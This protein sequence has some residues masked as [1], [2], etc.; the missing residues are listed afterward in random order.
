MPRLRRYA[1]AVTGSSHTGDR[2][3]EL[4]LETLIQE[5]GRL[6]ARRPTAVQ[7]FDL[8][9]DAIDAC[10]LEDE[11][12]ADIEF[13]GNL[14]RA[15]LRLQPTDR[16][17]VLLTLLEG[18]SLERAADMLVLPKGEARRRLAASCAVLRD[19]CV[20]RILVIE[21]K[22]PLA[23]D[24]ADL[25]SQSGHTLLGVAADT[26]SAAALAQRR[27]PD[28]IVVDLHRGMG[29]IGPV[30]AML[31][32]DDM[33]VVFLGGRPAAL[34]RRDAPV[35]VIDDPHDIRV[36][37]DAINRALFCRVAGNEAFCEVVGS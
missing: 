14:S 27:R 32:G 9:H 17:L 1:A 16:R 23:N 11:A 18:F 7:L 24:L 30:R 35:F 5:P 22:K 12:S 19:I 28:L 34:R 13:D 25:I 4:C 29:G 20:A 36:V 21:N 3:I 2:Y 15:I 8:L 37:E 33:P 26:R 10:G 31:E 6:D